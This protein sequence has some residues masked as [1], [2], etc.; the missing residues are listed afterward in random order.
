MA[1]KRF[2]SFAALLDSSGPQVLR[3]LLEHRR[4]VR[5]VGAPGS[6]RKP[7]LHV[8][9]IRS[10]CPF[11]TIGGNITVHIYV[12]VHGT[13]RSNECSVVVGGEGLL[14]VRFMHPKC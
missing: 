9:V 2:F 13:Q 3:Q 12:L 1:K 14:R 4:R 10:C 6:H 7:R 5:G 8:Q 11:A